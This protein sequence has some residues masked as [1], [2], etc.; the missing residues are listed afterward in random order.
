MPSPSFT[1]LSCLAVAWLLL[2]VSALADEPRGMTPSDYYDF[3]FVNDPQISPDGK[4]IAFVRGEV[5]DDRRSRET[6]I[7]LVG[8]DGESEPRRFT[9]GDSDGSPRWSPEGDRLAFVAS[10]NE[11]PQLHVIATD[12]GEAQA[13]TTLEQGTISDFHWLPE[14]D[15]ILLSLR[16]DPWVEDP[17]QEEEEEE[18]PQAD[19]TRI[20]QAVYKQEGRGLLDEARTGLWLLDLDSGELERLVHDE[21]WNVHNPVVSANGRHVAFNADKGGE[22]FDGGFNQDI[23][24]LDLRRGESQRLATPEGRASNPVFAPDGRALVYNHQAERY[25]PTELHRIEL[26]DEQVSVLHQGMELSVANVHWPAGDK[27]LFFHSDYRAS[28]PLFQLQGADG[29]WRLRFGEA[30]SVESASFSAD[31]RRVAWTQSDEINLPEIWVAD[32]RRGGQKRLTGFNDELL[33]GLA[34]RPLERFEFINDDDFEVD[35][36]VLRPVDFDRNRRYPVI[37]NIKGGPGGMW[38]HQWFH[39]YHMMAAQ[40]YAVIFTN[41]RGSTGYGHEFQS[42]VRLDYGGADYRDNMQLVDEA[43]ER[44]PWLDQEQLY[45]TGGSHGGFLT[46]WITTQSNRFQAAVTQRSV[47]SWISEAGTQMFPPRSMNAEFG[48]TL[49]DNFDYYWG[50]SPLKYADQVETPT[51]IIHADQDQITPIGQ[52][53]EW[54]YALLNNDVDTEMAIFHGEGHG[55]SRAGTPVN[56]V[57]RLELILEWFESYRD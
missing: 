50:R 41:Y 22:E 56:L 55:L 15:A 36:F 5:A 12:G 9:R 47:S 30:A 27:G 34:L 11:R 14:G 44:Y 54:F 1:Q 2:A 28:R 38:G 6:A 53:Q 51:L 43:L 48:G 49:W 25:A 21:S 18:E 39:E 26:G 35:G 16:L 29:N 7:W 32:T 19:L 31:G 10:R 4:K 24:L 17:R 13:L 33:N 42:A 37:L 57:K 23:Y 52:A 45:V 3:V 20:S 46:N 8:S 40:G